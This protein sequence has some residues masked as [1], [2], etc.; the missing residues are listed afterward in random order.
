MKKSIY[1]A[2]GF[3]NERSFTV[4]FVAEGEDDVFL[5]ITLW[6]NLSGAE[7]SDLLVERYCSI[8]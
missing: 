8:H 6:G 7:V 2:S 3:W 5:T 4:L 1:K